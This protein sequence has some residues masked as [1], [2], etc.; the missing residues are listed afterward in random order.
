MYLRKGAT[1]GEK[2][3]ED[4]EEEEAE[5]EKE[6]AR[7]KKCNIACKRHNS[8]CRINNKVLP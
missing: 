7:Y 6:R 1:E 3:R 2:E 5:E 4:E 8:F